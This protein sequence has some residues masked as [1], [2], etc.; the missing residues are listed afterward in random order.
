MKE[1]KF[2][3]LQKIT[4]PAVLEQGIKNLKTPKNAVNGGNGS[5][6]VKKPTKVILKV[7]T[8]DNKIISQDIYFDIKNVTTKRVTD[9]LLENIKLTLKDVIFNVENGYIKNIKQILE[10]CL[11]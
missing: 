9:R 6:I 1:A 8:E 10:N 2:L 7:I 4:Y 11:N 5:F 3:S